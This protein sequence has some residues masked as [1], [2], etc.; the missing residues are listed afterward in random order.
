MKISSKNLL[1]A[2]AK[3][4][5]DQKALATKAG[6]SYPVI[7]RALAGNNTKISSVGKIAAALGVDVSE[8][9]EMGD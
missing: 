5:I 4:Q 7:T 1:L 8:I 2:M 6:L 9:V 3:A